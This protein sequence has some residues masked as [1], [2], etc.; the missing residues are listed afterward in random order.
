[1]DECCVC[2]CLCCWCSREAQY[3]GCGDNREA[4][5]AIPPCLQPHVVLSGDQPGKVLYCSLS[6]L[7]YCVYIGLYCII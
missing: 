2:L 1:M 5:K 4:V 6:C 7:H 3:A